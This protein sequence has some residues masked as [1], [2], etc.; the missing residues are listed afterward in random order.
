MANQKD[1]PI[2][3][4]GSGVNSISSINKKAYKEWVIKPQVVTETIKYPHFPYL[5]NKS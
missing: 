3:Y 4:D 1:R 2:Y 5:S